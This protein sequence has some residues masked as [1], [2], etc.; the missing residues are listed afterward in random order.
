MNRRLV[1]LDIDGTLTPPGS[2]CVPDSARK[3]IRAARAAGHRVFLCTGR[4]LGMLRPVLACG[5]DGA[6]ASAGGYVFCGDELLFD[7]PMTATQLE[8]ALC[9]FRAG[10]VFV[11]VETRD[12][13]FCDEGVAEFLAASAG[14]NSELLRWRR[15]LEKELG[16]RP[17][18]EYDGKPVYKI[19]FSCARPEQLLPAR[20][21][22][23]REFFFLVHNDPSAGCL[24]GEL[25]NR[26]FDKGRG[27]RRVADALGIQLEETIGFG[28]SMNDLEMIRTVGTG[29][30][31]ENGN[32]AL[33][34]LSSLV[35]PSV[36]ED[37]IA[38]AF[39]ELGL[40]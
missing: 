9:A 29:V 22:L 30:C 2:N 13:S 35:C 24:N 10:D 32:P 37:G 8:T 27:V 14:G 6:V 23:E 33:K 36:E 17:M 4:N 15:Q 28:D 40:L 20:R 21:A 12:D 11:N 25:I 19:L 26:R 16:F 3:A 31:M 34:K 7:C 38:W 1:F 18:A 5:F 39:A